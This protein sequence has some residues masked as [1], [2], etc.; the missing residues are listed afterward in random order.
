LNF[1]GLDLATYKLDTLGLK[2]PQPILEITV[3]AKELKPGDVLEVVSDCQSFPRDIKFWCERTKR[4]LLF[5]N[6]EGGKSKAQ[7][8]F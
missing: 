4:V 7:I 3:K 1:E 6:T 2:C 8:Q 5:V